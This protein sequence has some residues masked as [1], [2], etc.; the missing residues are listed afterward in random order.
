MS[1]TQN[2]YS[3]SKSL[4]Q[5]YSSLPASPSFADALGTSF[6]LASSKFSTRSGTSSSSS[7]AS[8]AP[9]IP[10]SDGPNP[11]YQRHHLL[12]THLVL[13]FCLLHQ[14]FR[15]G[16]VHHRRHQLRQLHSYLNLMALILRLLQLTFVDG[17]VI[18]HPTDSKFPAI[19]P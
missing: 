5:I 19:V 12:Q 11:L 17:K 14:N 1:N 9:F 4:V 7:S 3:L 18:Q 13:R 2:E 16:L 8:S 6:L 15:L 10:E